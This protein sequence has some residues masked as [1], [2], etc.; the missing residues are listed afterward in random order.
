MV[1][2]S[3]ASVRG[4]ARV[5]SMTLTTGS[6]SSSEGGA[7]LQSVVG[8]AAVGSGTRFSAGVRTG[9]WQ[10]VAPQVRVPSITA[11]A[12]E[13]T[14]LEDES[15]EIHVLANDVT[16]SGSPALVRF[17]QPA[18]GTTSLLDADLGTILYEPGPDFHGTDSFE[19]V[20][21]A[22]NGDSARAVVTITI[23]AVNDPPE[24]ISDPVGEVKVGETYWYEA[25]AIDV[26]EDSLAFYGV[27]IPSWLTLT[28][29]KGGKVVITGI[30]TAT[31]VGT[32]EV[33]IAVNDGSEE[34]RHTFEVVVQPASTVS[35]DREALPTEFALE[36]NY[37]NPFNPETRLRFA[38][39]EAAHVTV[40]VFD[41]LGRQ[42][43]VL[44]DENRPAGRFEVAFDAADL[45]SGIYLARMH[46]GGYIGVV[47]MMLLK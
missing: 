40:Q 47:K 21:V 43:A 3:T 5:T 46:S 11:V 34:V 45:P 2:M 38:L 27:S 35:T 8:Q 24:F 15:V 7:R 28:G 4:Q 29:G 12:D 37:P 26:D 18:N 6:G 16:A 10:Q 19:Y 25:V 39:P 33:I 9:F 41:A 14:T 17:D 42:V 20:A 23:T 44:L 1:L 36:Q 30:P 32:V 13:V 31:D 22:S